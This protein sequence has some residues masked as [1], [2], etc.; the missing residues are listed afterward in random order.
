MRKR[1]PM[2]ASLAASIALLGAAW[3][4]APPTAAAEEAKLQQKDAIL[5]V[6][7][8]QRKLS[9]VD[10]S[11]Q[12]PFIEPSALLAGKSNPRGEVLFQGKELIVEVYEDDALTMALSEPFPHDEFI[13]VLNGVL[14]L[15]DASGAERTY[16][17][18]D[19]LVLPKGFTGTWN[20]SANFRELVVIERNVYDATYLAE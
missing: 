11:A 16:T 12:P 18:G 13:L 4:V 20:A 15:T 1:T 5:P 2:I 14:I 17:A 3:F 6:T 9:G 19:S 8:D 7:L 10:L